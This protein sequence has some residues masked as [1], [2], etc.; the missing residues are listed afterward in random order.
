MNRKSPVSH[1]SRWWRRKVRPDGSR[2]RVAQSRT[3]GPSWFGEAA[4]AGIS[5]V[6]TADDGR[7]RASDN[8]KARCSVVALIA[9]LLILAIFGGLGFAVHA[10]WIILVVALIL[11]LI[12]FFVGGV[13]RRRRTTWYGR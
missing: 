10:L 2:Q 3:S 7:R 13:E 11:W 12:G 6:R 4:H 9:L 8:E 1:E 5:E